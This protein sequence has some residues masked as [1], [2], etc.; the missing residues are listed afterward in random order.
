MENPRL[1][2]F[3]ELE[4]FSIC[5]EMCVAPLEMFVPCPKYIFSSVESQESRC[6]H[7]LS[8]AVGTWTLAASFSRIAE[9]YLYPWVT[10]LVFYEQVVVCMCVQE[11]KGPTTPTA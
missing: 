1:N 6:E 9:K 5:T 4:L 7:R 3:H 11:C 10:V 2:I 8:S